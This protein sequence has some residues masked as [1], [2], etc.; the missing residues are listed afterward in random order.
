[1][2]LSIDCGCF[3]SLNGAINIK[4]KWTQQQLK[5]S[6]NSLNGAINMLWFRII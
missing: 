4:R 2:I 1:M 3:N 6:F 5:H